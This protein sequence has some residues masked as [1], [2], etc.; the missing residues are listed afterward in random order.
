LDRSASNLDEFLAVC[1]TEPALAADHLRQ[2]YFEPWLRDTGHVEL[3]SAAAS[4][5][6]TT[7]SAPDA[8]SAFLRVATP[9]RGKS[10][11]RSRRNGSHSK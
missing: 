6:T 7:P 11:S 2:G 9:A 3:A 10:K 5:R 4:A 1:R 8:L